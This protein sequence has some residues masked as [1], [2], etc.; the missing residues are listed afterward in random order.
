MP[1]RTENTGSAKQ[2][3]CDTLQLVFHLARVAWSWSGTTPGTPQRL[4]APGCRKRRECCK[5][6][7]AQCQCL[8]TASP[9]C[10]ANAKLKKPTSFTTAFPKFTESENVLPKRLEVSTAQWKVVACGG[11]TSPK[12]CQL[13]GSPSTPRHW[14]L[15]MPAVISKLSHWRLGKKEEEAQAEDPRFDPL[16]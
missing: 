13:T 2:T 16:T 8:I 7:F 6:S 12:P 4:L 3:K 1:A 15:R 5:L 9:R 11:P 14:K 10:M